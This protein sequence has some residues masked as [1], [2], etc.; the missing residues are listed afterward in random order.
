MIGFVLILNFQQ[1]Y[2]KDRNLRNFVKTKRKWNVTETA[3]ISDKM[4]LI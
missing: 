4:N 2:T 1:I 3:I